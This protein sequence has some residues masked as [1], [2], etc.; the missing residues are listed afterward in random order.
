MC[1][2]RDRVEQLQRRQT[3]S[4]FLKTFAAIVVAY[5]LAAIVMTVLIRPVVME[6]GIVVHL[7]AELMQDMMDVKLHGRSYAEIASYLNSRQDEFLGRA[8]I[9]TVS[10]LLTV[11]TARKFG[12]DLRW[13]ERSRL[14]GGR[15]FTTGMWMD[16]SKH[17]VIQDLQVRSPDWNDQTRGGTGRLGMTYDVLVEYVWDIMHARQ[18][19]MERTPEKRAQFVVIPIADSPYVV[20]VRKPV[21]LPPAIMPRTLILGLIAALAILTLTAI[22]IIWPLV[23]RVRRIQTV[24][25]R[26][27]AGDYSAR[28]NDQRQDSLGALA[29]NVDEMTG[30]IERHLSQQKSLLQAVSHELRTPL[31]RIRFTIAMI[32]IPEDDAKGMERIDS[33]DDDLTEIDNMLKELSYFNYVD[34]GKGS[35]HFEEVSVAEMLQITL[36]QRSQPLEPFH[37]QIDGVSDDLMVTVDPTAFKRVVGNLLSNSARYAKEK[38]VVRVRE[39]KEDEMIEVAVEDDG[40]GI[41]EDKWKDVF[42]PFVCLDPSRSKSVG[43]VGLGLAICDRIMKIHHGEIRVERSPDGG[44]RM[45]TVWPVFQDDM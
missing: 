22:V 33:I 32:D 12:M 42:E 38:I 41:P 31:A 11:E 45:V 3:I 13:N 20:F 14:A 15:A 7:S 9:A 30:A 6:R 21:A 25:N 40:P 26:V 19:W 16:R 10:D 4:L 17:A 43:G 18:Q 5:S 24:C 36:K 34:A 27:T 35:D 23:R 44:A 28:C 39:L 29:N 8:Q 2:K 37:V 1:R